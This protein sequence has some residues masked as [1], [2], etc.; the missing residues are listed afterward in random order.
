MPGK[1]AI[2]IYVEDG[3]YHIYNRGVEKRLIFQDKMDYSV[4][5]AYLS[6]YLLPKDVSQLSQ[7]LASVSISPEEKEKV[8][9]LLRIKNFS[10][11]ITLLAYCLMPNHFHLFIKQKSAGS[12]DKFMR[13]L[14]TRYVTYFNRKNE[15]VGALF[16]GV[17]KAVLVTNEGQYLHLSRYIHKQSLSLQGESLQGLSLSSYPE[18]IGTRNTLWVHPQEILSFFSK[19]NPSFSY[20]RFVTEYNPLDADE[21]VMIE[22]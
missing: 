1:N 5:L 19:T 8:L 3:Y 14:C 21:R 2:K 10:Q 12:I 22:D 9:K 11:E 15:R 20:E 17:Y 7:K 18:Y 16:Q 13:S 6:D 4:F